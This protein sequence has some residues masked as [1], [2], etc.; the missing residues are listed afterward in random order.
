MLLFNF[1][2]HPSLDFGSW[3]AGFRFEC[4]RP[5]ILLN[6]FYLLTAERTVQIETFTGQPIAQI[7]PLPRA[8]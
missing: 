2:H 8:V 3:I 6:F 7:L 1:Y 4:L 5:V